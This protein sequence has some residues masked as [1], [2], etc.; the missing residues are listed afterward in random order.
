[1]PERDVVVD[2]NS[3]TVVERSCSACSAVRLGSEIVLGG[4]WTLDFF[5]TRISYGFSDDMIS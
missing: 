5:E 2:S 3:L 4:F 1:M